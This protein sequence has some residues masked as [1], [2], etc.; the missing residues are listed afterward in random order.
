MR[1]RPFLFAPATLIVSIAIT[2]AGEHKLPTPEFLRRCKEINIIDLKEARE[3]MRA[4]PNYDNNQITGIKI[5]AI[6]PCTTAEML[7]LRNDDVIE[8]INGKEVRS[9]EDFIKEF[10][11]FRNVKVPSI[12]GRRKGRPFSPSFKNVQFPPPGKIFIP[13]K[14][15]EQV[16]SNSNTND[17]KLLEQESLHRCKFEFNQSDDGREDMRAVLNYHQGQITGVKITSLAPC[18]QTLGLRDGDIIEQINEK[19]ILS[20][21]DFKTNYETFTN[22]EHPRIRGRRN[23][24]EKFALSFENMKSLPPSTTHVPQDLKD[25]RSNF[26]AKVEVADDKNL[27]GAAAEPKTKISPEKLAPLVKKAEE[28]LRNARKVDPRGF[29]TIDALMKLSALKTMA[30][31][32]DKA[33]ALVSEA[34]RMQNKYHPGSV[35]KLIE[36]YSR[37]AGFAFQKKKYPLA[38][39]LWRK[40]IAIHE[41]AGG[42]SKIETGFLFNGLSTALSAQEKYLEAEAALKK[43]VAIYEKTLDPDTSPDAKRIDEKYEQIREKGAIAGVEFGKH[44][45]QTQ[46]AS[47]LFLLGKHYL[48]RQQF[49]EA[50]PVFERA[51][52]KYED[53][54][55]EESTALLHVVGAY[56]TVL[57][58]T[59]N[60]EAAKQARTREKHLA[61]LKVQKEQ[62]RAKQ[63]TGQNLNASSTSKT[64]KTKKQT[65]QRR[66]PRDLI[67][68]QVF[69][70]IPVYDANHQII[71]FTVFGLDK[72]SFWSGVGL[73]DGDVLG[74]TESQKIAS[75][76]D[77]GKLL[78]DIAEGQIRSLKIKRDG[79]DTSIEIDPSSRR[80]KDLQRKLEEDADRVLSGTR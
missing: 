5:F 64:A 53:A 58:K 38:E 22:A 46:L 18:A 40:A 78:G 73:K 1:V 71:G 27:P 33:E 17:K 9:V 25:A 65:S 47:S 39:E 24:G 13:I 54:F 66:S 49:A 41:K 28:E 26:V 12:N 61:D 74:G 75:I 57:E 19:T 70:A 8:K 45:S 63:I 21:E 6:A 30:G 62:A 48:D 76:E 7:N 11:T 14:P 60:T 56:A 37:Q 23:N 68:F 10:A 69:R 79:K 67:V 4:V 2:S 3:D 72:N 20:V 15:L 55:G 51:L 29:A 36:I 16:T 59:G 32:S 42:A 80:W 50:K 31:N 44:P 43:A 35:K 34:E 52:K 77:V